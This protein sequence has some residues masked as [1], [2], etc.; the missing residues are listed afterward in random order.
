MVLAIEQSIQEPS[1]AD[2]ISVQQQMMQSVSQVET[3]EVRSLEDVLRK[4]GVKESHIRVAMQRQR[5]TGES[6]T[7]I[8]RPSDYGFLSPEKIAQVNAEVENLPYFAPGQAQVIDSCQFKGFEMPT[9]EG[10]VPVAQSGDL[11]TVAIAESRDSNKARHAFSRFRVECVIASERTIQSVYR[12][13]FANTHQLFD[14]ALARLQSANPEDEGSV[15]LLRELVLCV[16][17]HACYQSASDIIF[18]PMAADSGGVIRLK[19][20]GEGEIFRFVSWPIFKRLIN[21]FVAE[22]GKQE[23][24]RNRPVEHRFALKG[25]EISRFADIAN[26]YQ[27]RAM[28]IGRNNGNEEAFATMEMRILDQ[29]ADAADLSQLGFDPVTEK[30]INRYSQMKTGLFLVTGP[31]GSGKS[32]TLYGALKLIDP[33]SRWVQTI[34]NPIEYSQGLWMQYQVPRSAS[35][36]GEGAALI[37]KGLLR[38]APDVIL[39]GEVRDAEIGRLLLELANTGHLA[40]STLHANSAADAITR[41]KLFGLDMPGLASVLLGILAQRLVRCLCPKCKI[42]EDRAEV[43]AQMATDWIRPMQ[44]TPYQASLGGCPFCNYT[45]YHGRHMVYEL[46]DVNAN[47][48]KAIEDDRPPNTIAQAGIEPNGNL[49]ANAMRLVARGL[50]SM[51]V[52]NQ[53][54]RA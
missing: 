17:R 13:H 28:L 53:L 35:D 10:F 26:R 52:V 43:L 14:E 37:L 51:D 16:I 2:A 5:V 6:L 12:M 34:E 25:D 18:Q 27:F 24:L 39:Q 41:L 23:A 22:C 3:N 50:T 33:V 11:L 7:D 4:A 20:S 40:K 19:V 32:T 8:M 46:L 45:G 48:V 1:C 42:P 47:V 9:F 49:R 44:P 30:K 31:T 36:E 21:H 54:V 29:Q 15:G 38:N